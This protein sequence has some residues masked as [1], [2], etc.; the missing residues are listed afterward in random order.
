MDGPVLVQPPPH[1]YDAAG[2]LPQGR[3]PDECPVVGH[4]FEREGRLR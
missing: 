4:L 1:S 2:P 3:A